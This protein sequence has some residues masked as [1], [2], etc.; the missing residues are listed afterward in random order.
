LKKIHAYSASLENGE[1]YNNHMMF[2]G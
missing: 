1:K 2:I